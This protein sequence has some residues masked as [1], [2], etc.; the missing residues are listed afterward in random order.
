MVWYEL[1]RWWAYRRIRHPTMH[2]YVWTIP[3]FIAF[4]TTLLFLMLPVRPSITGRDGLLA[5]II[6]VLALLPGFFIAA[7]AAVAT[8]ERPEMDVEM[9]APAPTIKL[10]LG[11]QQIETELTRRMFLSYLFSYLSIA[12]LFIVAFCA[13]S[14]LL[15]PSTKLV[16]S[17]IDL[18]DYNDIFQF[19]LLF[20]FLFFVFYWCSNIIIVTLHGIFFLVERMHQP[21]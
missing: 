1:S 16:M 11:E 2:F 17:E 5:A 21:N 8:F 3:C 6:Q 9:P 13:A 14:E 4:G 12:S 19:T 15:A 20:W 18:G 10:N 7:L